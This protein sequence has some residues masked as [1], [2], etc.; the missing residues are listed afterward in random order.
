MG[1]DAVATR[2]VTSQGY[3]TV[4]MEIDSDFEQQEICIRFRGVASAELFRT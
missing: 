2:L 3:F 4:E 1:R